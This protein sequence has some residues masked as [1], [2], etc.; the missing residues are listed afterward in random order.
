MLM[1]YFDFLF[2]KFA[3][4]KTRDRLKPYFRFIYVINILAFVVWG[5]FTLV[6]VF[7]SKQCKDTAKDVYRLSFLLSCVFLVR[8]S[9]DIPSHS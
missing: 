4:V 1:T 7:S 2:E 8:A 3:G 9:T 5:I 6:Q